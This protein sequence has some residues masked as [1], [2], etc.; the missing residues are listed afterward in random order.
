MGIMVKHLERCG[1]TVEGKVDGDSDDLELKS[2][3]VMWLGS[4]KGQTSSSTILSA[5]KSPGSPVKVRSPL[6]PPNNASQRAP[7]S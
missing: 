6:T 4:T 5:P 7:R 3:S 2:I 1:V